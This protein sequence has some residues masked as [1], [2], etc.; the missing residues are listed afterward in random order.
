MMTEAEQDAWCDARRED[1]IE[2]LAQQEG[3]THGEV[4]DWPAWHF[5]PYVSLWAVE[6]VASPGMVGW[7]AIAGDVPT[8]YCSAADCQHPRLAV[9]RIAETWLDAVANTE[10][11][12]E[13]LAGTSLAAS[14]GPTVAGRAALLLKMAADDSA[15]TE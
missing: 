11:G 10:P 12:A 2:H 5:A 8:D 3:L 6:S 1:V 15:W 9:A 13:T 4:G 7:W 14:L